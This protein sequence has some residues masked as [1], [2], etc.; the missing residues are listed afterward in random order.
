MALPFLNMLWL[1]LFASKD[2]SCVDLPRDHGLIR[3][4]CFQIPASSNGAG[5]TTTSTC[6]QT[7]F[8]LNESGEESYLVTCQLSLPLTLRWT[9][10]KN[11]SS[12]TCAYYEIDILSTNVLVNHIQGCW[13]NLIPS[14]PYKLIDTQCPQ[15]RLSWECVDYITLGKASMLSPSRP[16][17]AFLLLSSIVLF[18][19]RQ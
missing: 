1:F 5:Y 13:E 16:I 6:K 8:L 18:A 15:G 4:R 17:R 3:E 11:L 9:F 2:D 7:S 14:L 10:Q 12:D 19:M